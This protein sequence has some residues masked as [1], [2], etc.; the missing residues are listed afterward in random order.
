MKRISEEEQATPIWD[1]GSPLYDSYELVSL[2]HHI[3]RHLTTVPISSKA[4][5]QFVDSDI[6]NFC[7]TT[8]VAVTTVGCGSA[9]K[10][11]KNGVSMVGC[12]GKFPVT[13][14]FKRRR[15]EKPDRATDTTIPVVLI[16]T[17]LVSCK[18][19]ATS[20]LVFL[21]NQFQLTTSSN[22]MLKL[23]FIRIRQPKIG[24]LVCKA[25]TGYYPVSLF[26]SLSDSASRVKWGGEIKNFEVDAHHASTQ[27][28][29]GHF[30]SEGYTRSSYFRHVSVVD[31]SNRLVDARLTSKSVTNPSCYDLLYGPPNATYGTYF[32]YG[33]PGFS[34]TCP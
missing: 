31:K 16:L 26:T 32:Y 18:Q 12:L 19:E 15:N 2:S 1:C 21:Y 24:G 33:G 11:G 23:F 8:I 27:M 25:K 10:K 4:Q 34:A 3:E 28:G 30:P 14:V 9:T 6:R 20:H 17:V 22:M 7:P 29:S 5:A 13:K